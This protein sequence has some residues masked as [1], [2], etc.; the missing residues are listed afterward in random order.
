MGAGKSTVGRIVAGRVGAPFVDLDD[1]VVAAAQKRGLTVQS[2]VEIFDHS[3]EA[4]FREIEAETFATALGA[5]TPSVIAVGGGTLLNPNSL[6]AAFSSARVV[7]LTASPQTLLDRTTQGPI[8]PLLQSTANPLQKVRELLAERAHVYAQAHATVCTDGCTAEQVADAVIRAWVNPAVVVSLGARS[9]PVRFASPKPLLF[10]QKSA[11]L[12]TTTNAGQLVADV[13]STLQPSQ[14]I[15]VTDF[16]VQTLWGLNFIEAVSQRRSTPLATVVLRPGEANK[17][18]A[19]V[20]KIL[21]TAVEQ[22]ADRSTV[23]VALGGGVVSD[24]AGLAASLL[25][26]GVKWVSVP[27]TLL[28]MADAAIGGKTGVDLGFAKNAVGTF[29]QPS[30]VVIDPRHVTTEAHRAYVS[31]LA[32]IVKSA[33]VADPTLLNYLEERTLPLAARDLPTVQ[34]AVFHAAQV[35]STIVAADEREDPSAPISRAV[36]NFG[37]TLGHALEAAG[38][39]ENLTHGEAVSLG[40]VAA[41]RVGKRLGFTPPSL[42]ARITSLL[43]TLGLPTHLTRADVEA[44]LPY[45]VNDKKRLQNKVRAVFLRAEGQAFVHP[46]SLS[47]LSALYLEAAET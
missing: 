22:G 33:A 8:R 42:A 47:D 15:L 36:L 14:W 29:H 32:E 39:F 30:A 11:S 23:I 20:Q 7:S 5:S 6:R 3:G 24:M 21:E 25:F 18:L 34:T 19:G 17:T 40:M 2:V 12:P 28:S 16:T 27:T 44:A 9:Y 43:S 4:F 13:L 35:K 10:E 31:G 38:G 46:V 1:R 41:L 45:L 37:H 26:R